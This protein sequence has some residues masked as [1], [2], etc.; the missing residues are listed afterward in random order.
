MITTLHNGYIFDMSTIGTAATGRYTR[1]RYFEKEN[2]KEEDQKKK[3]KILSRLF[4]RM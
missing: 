3:K 4:V 2:K 1:M